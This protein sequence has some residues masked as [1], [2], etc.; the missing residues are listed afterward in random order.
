LNVWWLNP[1]HCLGYWLNSEC[2]SC[3]IYVISCNFV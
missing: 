1:L 2:W 3:Y